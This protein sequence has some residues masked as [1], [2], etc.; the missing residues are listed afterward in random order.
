[1]LDIFTQFEGTEAIIV[2]IAFFMAIIISLSL[3]EFAHAYVAHKQ[4]DLTP[5]SYGRLTINPMAHIDPLGMIMLILLGF[6]WAKPVPV[7][8]I[9]FK[10][11]RLGFFLV[12]VAGIVVNLLL[13][14]LFVGL[15][16]LMENGIIPIN[17]DVSL[18][19][20]A[21]YFVYFLWVINLSLALFNLLPIAPLD[22]FNMLSATMKRDNAFLKFMRQYGQWVLLALLISGA[23]ELLLRTI[24]NFI[25]NPVIDFFKMFL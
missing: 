17:I 9:K 1:M 19:Y 6:G 20:F 16:V 25:A 14:L 11:Y 4:G 18:G 3:H 10:R 22:G 12:S 24:F 7:N 5:K 21:Y 23:L 8:P 15:F 2:F 13:F